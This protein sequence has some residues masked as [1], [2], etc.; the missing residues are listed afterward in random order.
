MCQHSENYFELTNQL[1]YGKEQDAMFNFKHAC[2]EIGH[3]MH[4]VKRV[5]DWKISNNNKTT[6]NY[7]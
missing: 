6:A 2:V 4:R 7:Y 1:D 5:I 3:K